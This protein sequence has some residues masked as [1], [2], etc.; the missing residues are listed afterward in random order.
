MNF[1]VTSPTKYDWNDPSPGI[2]SDRNLWS[3]ANQ[4]NERDNSPSRQLDDLAIFSSL[5]LGCH[6]LLLFKF[7][8]QNSLLYV[9]G[10]IHQGHESHELFPVLSLIACVPHETSKIENS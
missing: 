9:S 6:L 5:E 7:I 3:A 8:M 10:S 2:W 4:L 1:I